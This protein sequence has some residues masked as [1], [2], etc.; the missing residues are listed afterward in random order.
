MDVFGSICSGGHV[1]GTIGG[2]A[3]LTAAAPSAAASN[4]GATNGCVEAAHDLLLLD[5][6]FHP[7]VH[8]AAGCFTAI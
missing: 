6:S 5:A 8:T 2:C 7:V 4:G 1:S 3:L